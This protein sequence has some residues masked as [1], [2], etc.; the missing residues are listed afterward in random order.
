VAGGGAPGGGTAGGGTADGGAADGGV[1]LAPP[2]SVDGWTFYGAQQGLPA[3]VY[4]V[5]ADEGGNVYVA[6]GDALQVKTRTVLHDAA[7]RGW[8]DTVDPSFGFD[9]SWQDAKD[10]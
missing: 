2:I 3:E 10:V 5:S 9:A 8:A 4:D 7:R 6:G 1:A